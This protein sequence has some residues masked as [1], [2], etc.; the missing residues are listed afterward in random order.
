MWRSHSSHLIGRVV[1]LHISCGEKSLFTYDVERSHSSY[2]EESL[3][4]LGGVTLHIWE[5]EESLFKFYVESVHS[6]HLM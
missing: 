4:I 6:S 5:G 2:L 3:F 1:T